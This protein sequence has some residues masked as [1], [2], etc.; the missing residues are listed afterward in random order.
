MLNDTSG[1]RVVNRNTGSSK[2]SSRAVSPMIDTGQRKVRKNGRNDIEL[3]LVS[4]NLIHLDGDEVSYSLW[5]PSD[6]LRAY[7]P[8]KD[9]VFV[10]F[11]I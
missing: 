9:P 11:E 5:I 2:G 3:T 6:Q 7:D 4:F 10:P 1:N 8:D